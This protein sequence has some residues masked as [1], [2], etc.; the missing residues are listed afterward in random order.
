M[1]KRIDNRANIAG[2][3]L[4]LIRHLKPGE[5]VIIKSAKTGKAVKSPRP[6]ANYIIEAYKG[7]RLIGYVNKSKLHKGE[8]KVTPHKFSRSMLSR[9]TYSQQIDNRKRM[10]ETVKGKT[11]FTIKSTRK[12]TAQIPKSLIKEIKANKGKAFNLKIQVGKRK[13][14]YTHKIFVGKGMTDKALKDLVVS[15]T[16][17]KLS[18]MAVRISFKLKSIAKKNLDKAT[19]KKLSREAISKYRDSYKKLSLQSKRSA[20]ISV[21]FTEIKGPKPPSR[22]AK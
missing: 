16:I 15:T 22:R 1:A 17:S 11:K 2:G 3:K 4:S 10:G 12:M 8:L 21:E 5:H 19:K 14:D 13:I 6:G 7:K 18:S 20:Q 9:L